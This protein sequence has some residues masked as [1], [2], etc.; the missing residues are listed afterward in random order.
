MV[1]VSSLPIWQAGSEQFYRPCG[2]VESK[3][4]PMAIEMLT[5]KVPNL[6]PNLVPDLVPNLVLQDGPCP[7]CKC[8]PRRHALFFT[9]AQSRTPGGKGPRS[10][11]RVAHL[12]RRFTR[13]SLVTNPPPR[14]LPSARW[15]RYPSMSRRRSRSRRRCVRSCPICAPEVRRATW[16]WRWRS[17]RRSWRSGRC[18]HPIRSSACKCSPRRPPLFPTGACIRSEARGGA[19]V[20]GGDAL[21]IPQK[22]R[23][24]G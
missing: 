6:V 9:G 21:A 14:I 19:H 16:T 24:E 7:A 23:R 5:D 20:P 4:L 1:T 17:R 3:L 12:L 2:L 18:V 11:G 22:G 8:S 15:A 13:D 10:G